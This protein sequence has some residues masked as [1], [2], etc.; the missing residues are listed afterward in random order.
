MTYPQQQQNM[1]FPDTI[2]VCLDE[3]KS[4]LTCFYND[5]SFYIWDIKNDRSIKKHDSHM[6]HSGCGWGIEVRFIYFDF[7]FRKKKIFFRLILERTYHLRF[8]VNYHV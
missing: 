4:V 5:H 1:S 2:A 8:F 3:D 6:Y 7:F